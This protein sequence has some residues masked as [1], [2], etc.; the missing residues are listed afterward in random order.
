MGERAVL[1]Y[2]ANGYSARLLLPKLLERGITPIVAG[3]SAASVA[4]VAAELGLESRVFSLDQPERIDE[5]LAGVRALLNAAGPFVHTGGPLIDACLRQRVDY[6]DLTGEIEPLL[7]AAECD[8][9]ARRLGVML[10]PA[11][12][13]DVVPSDSLVAHLHAKLPGADRLVVDISPSNLLSRGSAAT[14]IA[15]AGGENRIRRDGRLETMRF[16]VQVRYRDFGSGMR[17]AIAASWGDLVTA[18]SLRGIPNIEVYFEATAFRFIAVAAN[19]LY[20]PILH[21]PGILRW[22]DGLAAL[23]PSSGPTDAERAREHAVVIVELSRG[24]ETVRARMTTP[25]AYTFTAE[26]AT[27]IL[28]AVLGGARRAGFQSAASVLGP[29]FV[30]AVPGVRRE[31]LPAAAQT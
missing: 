31:A 9:M 24:T 25:E 22:L 23:L 4:R 6:L 3:R 30:L 26:A 7:Y 12:G 20:A 19:E 16:R 13:F 27:R 11:V 2:G 10:M 28:G 17:P 29:D 8:P 18:Y 14:A 1:V 21:E 5:N 15:H